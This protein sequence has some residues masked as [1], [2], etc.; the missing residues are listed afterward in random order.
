MDFQE[1]KNMAVEKNLKSLAVIT[2]NE[3]YLSRQVVPRTYT[4][5]KTGF[6]L[7][8]LLLKVCKWFLLRQRLLCLPR[9]DKTK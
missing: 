8:L 6:F 5:E 3:K 1:R 2:W 7:Q 4:L 9:E